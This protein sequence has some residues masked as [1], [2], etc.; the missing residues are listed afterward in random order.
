[1]KKFI[2]TQLAIPD[3][4]LVEPKKFEDPRGFFSET[5]NKKDFSKAGINVDFVQDAYSFSQQ[6]V[7]RGLHFSKSPHETA[8]LVRCVQ[9]EILDIAVD[10]RPSSK[11]FGQW[12]AEKLSESNGK[13]LFIPQGFAHGF[14][15]LSEFA[16]VAYKVSDFYYPESDSGIIWNDP[17]LAIDWGIQKPILSDKDKQLPTLKDLTK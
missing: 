3:V 10:I 6:N 8:K 13:M 14:C 1:M 9:G 12:V 11:T 5:Y 16:G 4:I 7:I 15:I 2:F 17:D